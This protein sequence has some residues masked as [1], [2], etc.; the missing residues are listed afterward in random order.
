MKHPPSR[1]RR[2]RLNGSLRR[3]IR[4]GE[5]LEERLAFLR[6]TQG[7]GLGGQILPFR[8]GRLPNCHNVAGILKINWSPRVRL[9]EDQCLPI[10]H[11]NPSPQ[12]RNHLHMFEDN[13]G[14]LRLQYDQLD[15]N[16]LFADG[17]LHTEHTAQRIV[18]IAR[19]V[20]GLEVSGEAGRI[21]RAERHS[22]VNVLRG[23]RR[24]SDGDCE[25]S[26]QGIG[27]HQFL[28]A[29]LVQTVDDF[30]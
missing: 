2:V 12:D 19:L 16:D 22:Q 5:R 27:L 3:W 28:I 10:D 8:R 25:P 17:Q 30:R 4:L 21:G 20:A 7:C 11:G 24:S 13:F 26:D 15:R 14:P 23:S 29:R 1:G 18:R 9:Q 6:Q